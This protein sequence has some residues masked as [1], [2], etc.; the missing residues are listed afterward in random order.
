MKKI[1]TRTHYKATFLDA[2]GVPRL[3]V[4]CA[5]GLGQAHNLLHRLDTQVGKVRCLSMTPIAT[6]KRIVNEDGSIDNPCKH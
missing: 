4:I 3:K 2:S 5:R 1:R 6:C